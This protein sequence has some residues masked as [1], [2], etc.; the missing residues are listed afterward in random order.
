MLKALRSSGPL[1]E[2]RGEHLFASRCGPHR[3]RCRGGRAKFQTAAKRALILWRVPPNHSLR[4]RERQSQTLGPSARKPRH[5]VRKE[6]VSDCGRL[7]RKRSPEG[8]RPKCGPGRALAELAF[9]HAS[10]HAAK[11]NSGVPSR[12]SASHGVGCNNVHPNSP[13]SARPIP[14]KP[15]APIRPLLSRTSLELAPQRTHG[16]DVVV[17]M[18]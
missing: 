15:W 18:W 7:R 14:G 1:D 5:R 13:S 3:L 10:M 2:A 11:P 4:D 16:T 12:P 9:G 17:E 6:D 8:C